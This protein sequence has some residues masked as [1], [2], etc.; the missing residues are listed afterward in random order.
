VVSSSRKLEVGSKRDDFEKA[1]NA[2]AE[3]PH[4]IDADHK[5]ARESGLEFVA[6][7]DCLFHFEN[8]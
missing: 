2:V 6:K 3:N 5:K 8:R 1:K 7:L 4:P